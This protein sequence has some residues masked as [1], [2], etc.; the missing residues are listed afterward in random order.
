MNDAIVVRGIRAEGRHG[1]EADGER[2]NAQTFIVDV[3]LRR[4][5]RPAAEADD[6]GATVDY[7][8]VAK[9]V[10]EVV[11]QESFELLE[12][13]ANAIAMRVAT[14]GGS[15]VHVKVSKPNAATMAGV[16]EIA[17]VVERG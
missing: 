12:S 11:E 10:R 1:I 16:E 9:A 6:L 7:I 8:E 4:D 5:L 17:V 2:D 3:E 13:L 15:S 14:L